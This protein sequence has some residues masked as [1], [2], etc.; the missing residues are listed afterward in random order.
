MVNGVVL[1]VLASCSGQLPPL[2]RPRLGAGHPARVVLEHYR[3]ASLEDMGRA[4]EL[5]GLGAQPGECKVVS[6][7]ERRRKSS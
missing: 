3:R 2:W 5:A 7:D 1:C 6:L 4:V